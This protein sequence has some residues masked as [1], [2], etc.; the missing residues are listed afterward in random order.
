M[1][2]GL[3]AYGTDLIMQSSTL[4]T[5]WK[6]N[7]DPANFRVPFSSGSSFVGSDHGDHPLRSHVPATSSQETRDV[8][9]KA[10]PKAPEEQPADSPPRPGQKRK[11]VSEGDV[12]KRETWQVRWRRAPQSSMEWL[13]YS[14]T[15]WPYMRY[16]T[17]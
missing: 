12:E 5:V 2:V 9:E 1:L 16:I 13:G 14:P 6:T 4:D 17:T 8:R 10:M 11:Q 7:M 3:L 15:F